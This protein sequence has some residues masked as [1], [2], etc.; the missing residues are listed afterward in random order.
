M[1]TPRT[2][3]LVDENL[4]LH[5]RLREGDGPLC[6]KPWVGLEERSSGGTVKPCCW[7]RG[8]PFGA[9]REGSDVR[10]LWNGDQ[11]RALRRAM[12]ATAPIECSSTCPIL[13][14]RQRWFGKVELFDYSRDE[15]AALTEAGFAPEP[16]ILAAFETLR[17]S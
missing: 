10:A 13:T 11:A 3:S 8:A 6:L 2:E 12:G 4:T 1:A 16:A 15:L 17:T 14:T 9:I 5:R 7:Y